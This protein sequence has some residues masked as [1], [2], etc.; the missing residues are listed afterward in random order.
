MRKIRAVMPTDQRIL[1]RWRGKQ[2]R[3][4][5]EDGRVRG[6]GRA[7][8]D[9][10]G[11]IPTRIGNGAYMWDS[12]RGEGRHEGTDPWRLI[13]AEVTKGRELSTLRSYHGE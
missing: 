5:G 12:W 11:D 6:E 8:G 2:T 10:K 9:Q 4:K 1:G 7:E 13:F 3:W